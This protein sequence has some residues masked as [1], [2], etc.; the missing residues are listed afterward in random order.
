MGVPQVAGVWCKGAITLRQA[1]S[2]SILPVSNPLESKESHM[3]I[4][5]FSSGG[6]LA[7][8][9]SLMH[10]L[11]PRPAVAVRTGPGRQV[12]SHTRP[13]FLRATQPYP[14]TPRPGIPAQCRQ[15]ARPL[16]VFRVST[17]Q[18]SPAT[19]ARMAISGT[20]ADVCAELDRL[21]AMEAA[22]L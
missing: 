19:G 3:G 11:A 10:W 16:R 21:A 14:R 7:P 9:Q 18:Q 20:M 4:A 13:A 15:A 2:E 17:E 22:A 5:I 1:G 8:F 12:S 6:L